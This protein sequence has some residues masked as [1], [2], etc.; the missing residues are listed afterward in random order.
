[1]T[2]RLLR[3]ALPVVALAWSATAAAQNTLTKDTPFASA[4]AAAVEAPAEAIE[5]AGVVS[6]VGKKTDLIFFDKSVK[7]FRW[8]PL[9]ETVDGITAL[10]YDER[11]DQAVVKLNGVQKTLTL[12]KSANPANAPA[13]VAALQTGFN[14]PL[15]VALPPAA[16]MPAPV[17]QQPAGFPAMNP[18]TAPAP[19]PGTTPAA[20]PDTQ[21]KQETEARMLV[22]DLLEIGM[23][24][25]KAYEE[26]QRKAQGGSAPAN[27]PVPVAAPPPTK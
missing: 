7:K 17:A 26:A 25:R 10:N 24:Q 22:S 21:A 8:V 27:P 20:A 16:A 6:K 1:M 13:P 19:A 14:T 15:P 9:G 5:F 3:S 4:N 18:A 23:A 2:P 11:L 12:R